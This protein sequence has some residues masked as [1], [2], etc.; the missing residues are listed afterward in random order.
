MFSIKEQI[1]AADNNHGD[2]V[3]TMISKI[4]IS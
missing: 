4:H 2:G 1:N 3:E